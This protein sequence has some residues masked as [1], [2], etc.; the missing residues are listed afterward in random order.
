V[1]APVTRTGVSDRRCP[2]SWPRA[3]VAPAPRRARS[4]RRGH[5]VP[6]QRGSPGRPGWRLKT[7]IGFGGQPG[8]RRTAPGVGEQER[9]QLQDGHV[10]VGDRREQPLAAMRPGARRGTRAAGASAPRR[11][12]ARQFADAEQDAVVGDPSRPLTARPDPGRHQR[13]DRVARSPR[14]CVQT[15]A[16][17]APADQQQEGERR[18]RAG[19]DAFGVGPVEPGSGTSGRS[20]PEQTTATTPMTQV[21]RELLIPPARPARSPVSSPFGMNPRT[22]RWSRSRR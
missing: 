4:A 16:D 18:R 11:P 10:H 13:P 2:A 1:I 8:S 22:R 7:R 17:E 21:R 20:D 9:R 3:T 6:A 14:P 19:E 12:R 15:G 5:R